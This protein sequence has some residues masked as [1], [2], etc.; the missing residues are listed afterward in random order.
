MDVLMNQ[1]KKEESKAQTQTQAA[2]KLAF[3]N[4]AASPNERHLA[5]NKKSTAGEVGMLSPALVYQ[6]KSYTPK[7]KST[8]R[9]NS[10]R[11]DRKPY[12]IGV[13]L[14][15]ADLEYHRYVVVLRVEC[16]RWPR[17]SRM[18]CTKSREFS[19]KF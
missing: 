3:S 19:L 17:T 6:S 13:S 5:V 16:P 12:I 10:T 11:G 2:P 4:L 7:P 18:S 1:I 14:F 15:F 9:K 8:V